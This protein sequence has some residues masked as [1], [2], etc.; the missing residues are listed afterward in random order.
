M[1][2]G[3]IYTPEPVAEFLANWAIQSPQDRVLDLGTGPGVFV[4][5]AHNR[6]QALGCD[7]HDASQQIYG[8]EIDDEAWSDFSLLATSRGVSFPNISKGDF[9]KTTLTSVDA[10]IGN[11][12]YVRRYELNNV[13]T[14]RQSVLADEDDRNNVSRLTD[15]Y[16]YFLLRSIQFLRQEGRLA[17]ITADSWLNVGYGKILKQRLLEEFTIE[18]LISID[19]PVFDDA[20]VKPVLLLATKAHTKERWHCK[21]IR[22]KNGLRFDDLPRHLHRETAH[23][24]IQQIFVPNKLLVPE[25]IWS[26]HFKAPELYDDITAH[27]LFTPLSK[28]AR[29]QIGH[30]T[31]AKAFFVLTSDMARALNIEDR[32]LAPL[33]QSSQYHD[34]PVISKECEVRFYLFYCSESK[35][36]LTGTHA[37]QYIEAGETETVPIRGK[38]RKVVGYHKKPRIQKAS[39]QNWYDL[40]T[41][42]EARGRAEILI[43]R[44]VYRDFAVYWNRAQYVPGELFIEFVPHETIDP[45]VYLA[46]LN[47]TVAEV[48]FRCHAQVYGGGTYNMN[49]GEI[50][51]MPIID[52]FRLNDKQR[53]M[54]A[55]SYEHFI[56]DPKSGRRSIDSVVSR[57]L[58]FDQ[59]MMQKVEET[60]RDLVEIATAT[61]LK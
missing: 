59:D 11:P 46:I 29:A 3:R 61:K 34:Y 41:R 35:E 50:K 44:L 45:R 30:Q 22:V 15:L 38:G 47:S 54:L 37:L 49:S 27:S 31:L 25:S 23:K 21:F 16:V 13:D 52:A 60:R 10:V 33:A 4:F 14:I 40:R 26:I 28:I 5:Q 58:E 43:P 56:Q 32:F 20:Q 48:L 19:R 39:R 51:G 7:A 36:K 55:Q 24:D 42:L 9:F 18:R 6:L 1:N 2:N 12:P 57:I 17:V 53:C 8:A